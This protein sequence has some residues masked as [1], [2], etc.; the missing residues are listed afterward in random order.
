VARRTFNKT[1]VALREDMRRHNSQNVYAEMRRHYGELPP[2][3]ISQLRV[4]ATTGFRTL[5]NSHPTLPDRLRAAYQT[6]GA[7]PPSPPPTMPAYLLLTPAGA[8]DAAAVEN[9]VTTMLF[10]PKKK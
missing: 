9:E 6:F 1:L 4:E 2:Q 3:I 8:S 10:N 5:A 7:L